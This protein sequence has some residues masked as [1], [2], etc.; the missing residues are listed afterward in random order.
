MKNKLILLILILLVLVTLTICILIPFTVLANEMNS[1]NI[2]IPIINE[3]NVTIELIPNFTIAVFPDLQYYQ[4]NNYSEMVDLF[5]FTLNK[6]PDLILSIGDFHYYENNPSHPDVRIFPDFNRSLNILRNQSIP[7]LF[8]PGNHDRLTYNELFPNQSQ[9]YY[10]NFSNYPL[11]IILNPTYNEY[12]FTNITSNKS[13]YNYIFVSHIEKEFEDNNVVMQ[14][15]GHSIHPFF[16]MMGNIFNIKLGH[17]GEEF[18]TQENI[19]EYVNGSRGLVNFYTFFPTL[20]KIN[21]ITIS[22]QNN[23][24]YFNYTLDLKNRT[25]VHHAGKEEWK[26]PILPPTDKANDGG[27][28]DDSGGSGGGM[29]ITRRTPKINITQNKTI[30]SIENI[31]YASDIQKEQVII[32]KKRTFRDFVKVI[33]YAIKSWFQR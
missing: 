22:S 13:E 28:G 25:I 8:A 12:N 17:F 1:T 18:T 5:N 3:T 31:T 16:K 21:M 26:T 33:F 11:G 14:L 7:W 15:S 6:K 19:T 30:E 29:L 4:D 23:L 27:W 20:K 32:V 2:T 24:T 10:F 9:I